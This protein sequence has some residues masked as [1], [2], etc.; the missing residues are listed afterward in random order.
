[1]STRHTIETFNAWQQAED[2]LVL[3]TVI[4]TE[5]STYSKSGHRILIAGNGHYQGLVSGGCLEGDLAEHAREVIKTG[6]AKAV[7]YDLRDDADEIWGMGIGCNGVIEVLLQRL[8]RT[9][10]FEP[11]ATIAATAM[12]PGNAVAVIVVA[13]DTSACPIGATLIDWH[14]GYGAFDMSAELQTLARQ[15]AAQSG[16]TRLVQHDT[17][18]LLITKIPPVPQLLIL[19]AGPDAVPLVNIASELGWR[20]TIADHR[21]EYL[22]QPAFG[23]AE[24]SRHIDPAQL[25]SIGPLADFNAVVVMS[26]HLATDRLYLEQLAATDI[27]YIGLLGPVARRERLINDLGTAAEPLRPRLHGPV[28]LDIGANSPES[29]ALSILAQIQRE[30]HA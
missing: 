10:G 13:S 24:H 22:T 1:M 18:T 5:G 27:P 29:I 21:A 17:C 4:E 15:E 25:A 3:A 7:R 19:G 28:G 9:S 2:A 14:E 26:H 30:T 11:Y 12:T 23:K 8:N 6:I 20:I 16:L